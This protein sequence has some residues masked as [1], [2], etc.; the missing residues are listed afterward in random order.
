M[1]IRKSLSRNPLS[2]ALAT[3]MVFAAS[4]PVFA[5]DS[6]STQ[7]PEEAAKAKTTTN[8][9]TVTVTGSRI[10][11][12]TFNSV[13]PVQ[14]ITRQ[15]S[16]LAG[17]NSTTDALQSTA[18]TAGSSQINNAYGG[19]VTDGG[20]GANTLGLRGLGPTR[21]LILLNGRR[22]APAGSRGAVG[23]AD[24][25]VLPNAIVDRIEILKDGASSIY[26][27]D[28]VAG[29]INIITKTKVDGVSFEAQHNA[30]DGGGGDQRRYSIMFG[31][32]GERSHFSGSYEYYTRNDM[33]LRDR[34]WTRCATDKYRDIDVGDYWGSGDFIDPLTGKSK[35]Y[36]I[37][38]G[39]VTINTI[40][41]TPVPVLPPRVARVRAST[42]SGRTPPSPPVWWATKAWTST[43]ATP[44]TTPC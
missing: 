37:D 27:S 19:Y 1:M 39:G 35:C 11:K 18:V 33:S 17:F 8:F 24:L 41:T 32:T 9:D 28:A 10:S 29:V 4:A 14:V 43:P 44:S 5:Q 26:G 13:S 3:A 25:N 30:T 38:A 36:T 2:F 42:A 16:L 12:D 34:D 21:T 40:G 23:S 7:T 31:T 15:E 20:P 22:V 6:T